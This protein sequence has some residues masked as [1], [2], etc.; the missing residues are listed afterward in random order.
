VRL[1]DADLVLERLQRPDVDRVGDVVRARE[2]RGAVGRRLDGRVEVV[3]PDD[4]PGD[5]AGPVEAVRVDVR[6]GA[7]RVRRVPREDVADQVAG[8]HD[9]SGADGGDL[10]RTTRPG[11]GDADPPRGGRRVVRVRV[12][13]G[14]PPRV[15]PVGL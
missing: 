5:A 14:D 9:A 7:R 12:R 3:V 15:T 10:D 2:R 8:E 1:G 13:V 6:R 4:P 11:R